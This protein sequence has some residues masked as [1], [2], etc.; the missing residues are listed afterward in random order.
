MGAE[1]E[2]A[3]AGEITPPPQQDL[4]LRTHLEPVL[5]SPG[6]ARPSRETGPKLAQA[7]PGHESVLLP[8]LCFW[9]R[10]GTKE[11]RP[12]HEPK[13]PLTEAEKQEVKDIVNSARVFA[14]REA[15]YGSKTPHGNYED[16]DFPMV[17]AYKDAKLALEM[18]IRCI[19]LEKYRRFLP[20]INKAMEHEENRAYFD[21]DSDGNPSLYRKVEG[22][23]SAFTLL[24]VPQKQRDPNSCPMF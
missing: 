10:S 13:P 22:C 3:K 16:S 11:S 8:N 15:E 23:F 4:F 19:G 1:R 20:E 12:Q 21:I 9:T 17:S 14:N 7:L 5:K 24:N 18:K 2:I 6:E